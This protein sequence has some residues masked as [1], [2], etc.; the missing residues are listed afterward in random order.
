MKRTIISMVILGS[1]IF[2]SSCASTNPNQSADTSSY[3]MSQAPQNPGVLGDSQLN[4]WPLQ[5]TA[6][7]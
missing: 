5:F 7:K 6:D 2:L 3:S 4:R 1:A